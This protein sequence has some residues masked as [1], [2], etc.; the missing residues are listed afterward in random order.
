MINIKGLS[1]AKVLAALYNHSKPQGMGFLIYDP[2][3][4]TEEGAQNVIDVLEKEG[5]RLY[6][7]YIKGRVMKVDITRDKLDPR[8]YDRDNGLGAADLAIFSHIQPA[9]K[10]AGKREGQREEEVP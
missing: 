10:F 2:E 5:Y 8:L 7:D 1:K 6:F 9:E 4:M 3:P